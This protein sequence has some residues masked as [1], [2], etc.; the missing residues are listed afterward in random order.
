MTV[1]SLELI[2]I[3]LIDTVTGMCLYVDINNVYDYV[4]KCVMLW[5]FRYITNFVILF[6][7]VT[8]TVI[9]LY[10]KIWNKYCW[11]YIIKRYL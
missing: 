3:F 6:K 4:A 11:K 9:S 10:L 8:I 2:I 7:S 1:M 5:C